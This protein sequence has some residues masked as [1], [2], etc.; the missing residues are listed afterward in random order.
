[1]YCDDESFE[2]MGRDGY[3]ALETQPQYRT[4]L[5]MRRKDGEVLWI[6][7]GAARLSE[8]E[9]FVMLID[10]T[11]MKLAHEE[12]AHAAFHD[13]LTQL[14]NRSLLYD[15]IEQALA[16]SAREQRQVAIGYL[17]LDGFKAVNDSYGHDAGR[18]GGPH[19]RRRVRRAADGAG[20]RRLG[21][22][23]PAVVRGHRA[24]HHTGVGHR[25]DGRR[26][27]GRGRLPR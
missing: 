10:I 17:D 1:M 25:R 12:L 23:L 16:V 5:R 3:G 24:A 21:C 15:R 6:D 4:Q 2:A 20:A 7:F 9:I 22:H 26:N 13:A 14:P 19:R 18:H 8:T 11:A 27:A